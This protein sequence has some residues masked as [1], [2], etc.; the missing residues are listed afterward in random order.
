MRVPLRLDC[1]SARDVTHLLHAVE[2]GQ[3]AG[4]F[5]NFPL[6]GADLALAEETDLEAAGMT[7]HLERK[8]LLS[9][10]QTFQA[11]GVPQELLFRGASQFTRSLRTPSLK[12]RPDAL[13]REVAASRIARSATKY[14]DGRQQDME[15]LLPP[16]RPQTAPQARAIAQSLSPHASCEHSRAAGEAKMSELSFEGRP[17]SANDFLLLGRTSKAARPVPDFKAL[18]AAVPL[19]ALTRASKL[20]DEHVKEQTAKQAEEE[21]ALVAAARARAA[22]QR[23]TNRQVAH[24][25]SESNVLSD[26]GTDAHGDAK[27]RAE[28]AAAARRRAQ[29]AQERLA[30]QQRIA[31]RPPLFL[32]SQTDAS[33]SAENLYERAETPCADE[34]RSLSGA[35]LRTSYATPSVIRVWPN[36]MLHAERTPSTKGSRL[37][38]SGE[39][40]VAKQLDHA[41]EALPVSQQ[42]RGDNLH[43][44]K[45]NDLLDEISRLRQELSSLQSQLGDR[46]ALDRVAPAQSNLL[47]NANISAALASAISESL[48]ACKRLAVNVKSEQAARADIIKCLRASTLFDVIADAVLE[49]YKAR[50]KTPVIGS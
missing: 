19:P 16:R 39:V 24:A 32:G 29:D 20:R 6:T 21:A 34:V 26:I 35:C 2:L 42:E 18:H 22:R 44:A 17:R 49:L 37:A 50:S 8:Q 46:D 30:M 3:Y 10:L 48:A 5:D 41:D 43:F 31:Q 27:R 4:M 28:K 9:Q 40:L 47:G 33:Q 36:A 45:V 23:E 25:L 1:L 12:A 13:R 15:S 14:C 38:G 7:E 11:H